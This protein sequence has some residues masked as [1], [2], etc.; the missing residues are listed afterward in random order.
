MK[1]PPRGPLFRWLGAGT[2]RAG[3]RMRLALRA[4][5]RNIIAG[6]RLAL[7]M[8]VSRLAFRVDA[9]QLLLLFLVSCLIDIGGDRFRFGE[10]AVFAA[11]GAGSELAGIALLGVVAVA[12]AIALRRQALALAISV[13]VMASLPLVQV[14]HYLPFALIDAVPALARIV[15]AG[16]TVILAW[17]VVILVRSVAIHLDMPRGRR[18][19][20]AAA[21]AIV[22]AL[23]LVFSPWLVDDVPWYRNADGGGAIDGEFSAASEPVL[24]AQKQLLD[25]ALSDIDDREPGAPNLYFVA[26]APD[27][28]EISWTPHMQRVQK[29][30][31][32][33]LD[34]KGRSVV[35]RNH[36]DTM[37]TTPFATVSNLRETFAE[38]AAAA[39]V[40]EDIL[41]LYIGGKGEKGGRIP[42]TMPP[43][44]L[45][46]LTPVGLKSLLDDAG[47]AWR[48]VVVAACYAGAYAD[49]LDDER[50]VVVAASGVDQPSFGCDGRGDPAFFGDALFS[51]GF[52]QGD[53][54][55][56]AFDVA[57]DRVAA[58][59]AERGLSASQ[60]VMR[61]G[62][63][64]APRIRHLRRF[65]GGNNA[66]AW[67]RGSDDTMAE[68][69]VGRAATTAA[70]RVGKSAT[71]VALRAGQLPK[72]VAPGG[73][74]AGRPV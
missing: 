8:P 47:F 65:G 33:R 74:A 53:S 42:V 16:G 18:W 50:T 35:L 48:I 13:T 22:L 63:R 70:L 15:A 28:G 44:D 62:A 64:I 57:R 71:A 58:R 26:F 36:A 10:D 41:M 69:R 43:L 39:D 37:L 30:V 12:V 52:A 17:M 11:Q 19:F 2:R 4:L 34:T 66:T 5:A 54:L 73:P 46:A 3:A 7:F 6:L 67:L 45:V 61:V 27:A 23:P 55:V 21:S 24:A 9:L 14:V 68:L 25:D 31:D 59:E 32:D 60:P 56:A 20:A 51:A 72:V 38:I 1:I 29:L 49:V 40:D